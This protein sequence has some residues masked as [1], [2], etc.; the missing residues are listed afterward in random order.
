[1]PA[2][3][4]DTAYAPFVAS[5][6]AGGFRS[7]PDGEWTAEQIAA[8]IT[9]NNDLIAEAAEKVAAGQEV[10]YD[11]APGVDGAELAGL[12]AGI[13]GL[14]GLARD[15]ERSA[16]RLAKAR[17]S[18]GDRAD[19]LIPV[20]IRDGGQI[21]VDRQ[22]PIGGLC[23]GNAT[24]HLD[25]H[26]RQLKALEPDWPGAPPAEFDRYQ[27]VLLER[28]PGA[29]TLDDEAAAVLQRQHLGHFA[30]MQAAGLM[31]VSGPVR[32]DTAIAGISIYRAGTAEAARKLAEDDPAVRS[33]LYVIRAMDWYTARDAIGWPAA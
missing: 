31:M 19:T 20:V 27:L 9:R 11:N 32:H 13:G 14:A 4:L 24:F 23:E 21:A 30:K 12:A 29:P 25:L 16:A 5:L 33:G 3:S 28:A 1:M 2:E 15:I 8:H 22:M 17:D 10:S 26:L 18:L 6:L 7:P